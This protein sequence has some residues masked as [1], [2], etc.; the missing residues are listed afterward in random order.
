VIDGFSRTILAWEVRASMKEDEVEIV[1]QKARESAPGATPRIIS[2]NGPQFVAR[3]FR[4]FVRLTGMT[5]VRTSPYYPQSNGRIELFHKTIKAEAIRRLTPLSL[6]DAR[7]VVGSFVEHY[8]N[9]RLHSAVGYVAPADVLAGKSAGDP[10]RTRSKTGGGPN[11]KGRRP[12]RRKA[13]PRASWMQR[14]AGVT[15]ERSLLRTG[16]TA[17]ADP[18]AAATCG[19]LERQDAAPGARRLHGNALNPP[20]PGR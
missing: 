14:G 10:R 13:A 11:R 5:H 18:S 3:D 9:V 1:L 15:I 6:D 20:N 4:E 7:R 8:N 17:G 2:D 16:Q 12:R 19:R